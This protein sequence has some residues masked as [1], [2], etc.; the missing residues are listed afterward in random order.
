MNW[1]IHLFQKIGGFFVTPK[2]LKIEQEISEIVV[3]AAP[4]VKAIAAA[5]PNKTVQEVEA[6]FQQFGVP[7]AGQIANDPTSIGNAMLNL[8]SALVTKLAPNS[9]LS[10]I[11][12]AIQLALVATKSNA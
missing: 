11:Q 8:A 6:A 2:A 4:I 12:A 10:T 9:N 5:V 1:L 7:V 3:Q